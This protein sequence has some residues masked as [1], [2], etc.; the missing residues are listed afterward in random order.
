MGPRG[1]LSPRAEELSV[2]LGLIHVRVNPPVWEGSRHVIEFRWKWAPWLHSWAVMTREKS[3]SM[4]NRAD[5]HLQVSGAPL[6]TGT[7]DMGSKKS[8]NE[9]NLDFYCFHW[10][11]N[12]D[13]ICVFVQSGEQQWVALALMSSRNVWTALLPVWHGK[14]RRKKNPLPCAWWTRVSG[15]WHNIKQ[16][17]RLPVWTPSSFCW[18]TNLLLLFETDAIKAHTKHLL[19]EQNII[20]SSVKMSW[21]DLTFTRNADVCFRSQ[22]LKSFKLYTNRC[23]LGLGVGSSQQ[24]NRLNAYISRRFDLK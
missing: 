10:W 24:K 6:A 17:D 2:S 12:D 13:V 19:H 3:Y 8:L 14:K 18:A 9:S 11:A 20:F 1:T 21:Y 4:T 23:K 22:T 16:S 15:T 7:P 5:I